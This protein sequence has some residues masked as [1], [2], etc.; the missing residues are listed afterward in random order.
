MVNR[1]G[2]CVNIIAFYLQQQIVGAYHHG[3]SSLETAI[4]NMAQ[5]FVGSNNLNLLFPS[6]QFGTRLSG[7]SD[8]AS[9]HLII[10]LLLI[11]ILASL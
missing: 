11:F 3:E 9:A 2:A 4:V 7:G 1:V 10:I 5:D 8:H 6:G